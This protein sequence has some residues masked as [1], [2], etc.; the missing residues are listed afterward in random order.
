MRTTE[1]EDISTPTKHREYMRARGLTTIDDFSE[2]RKR[3][4]RRR[5][6]YRT[7]G[8]GGA[9]TRDEVARAIDALNRRR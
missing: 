6:E 1:G 8:K 3:A 7:T 4:E 5:D 2:S 9:T